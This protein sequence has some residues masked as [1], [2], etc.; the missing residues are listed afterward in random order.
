MT[1]TALI[2]NNRTLVIELSHNENDQSVWIVRSWKKFLC[3][4]KRHSSD[5]LNS[6]Q[7]AITFAQALKRNYNNKK[8][9]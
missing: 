2:V 8:G 4:R 7:Q 6:E 3:F 5:W 1:T 9:V